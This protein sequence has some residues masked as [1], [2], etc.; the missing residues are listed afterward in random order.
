MRAPSHLIDD[1]S[2]ARPRTLLRAPTVD[3]QD[4]YCLTSYDDPHLYYHKAIAAGDLPMTRRLLPAWDNDR[5]MDVAAMHGQCDVLL[6]LHKASR[7]GCT[8]RAMDYAAA[9]GQMECLRFLHQFRKE[10]CSRQA[11]LYAV[12]NDHVH[13]VL[14]L[15]RH[16][17]QPHWFHLDAAIRFAKE[18]KQR[19][20]LKVL[21]QIRRDASQ[22]SFFQRHLWRPLRTRLTHF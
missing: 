22:T 13:C 2:D 17:P 12:R 6:F 5:A 21:Q 9:Y 8:T 4:M 18:Y 15:W 20:V 16:Q 3:E 7:A 19:R 11:L 10:G 1:P 14:Y